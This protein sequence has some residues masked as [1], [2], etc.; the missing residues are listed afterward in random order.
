MNDCGQPVDNYYRPMPDG[1][2][3]PCTRE[4][5]EALVALSERD[6]DVDYN[7]FPIYDKT[8]K[9]QYRTANGFKLQGK[10]IAQTHLEQAGATT[11]ETP[12]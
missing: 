8:N 3:E 2:W 4:T 11:S 5:A 12:C 7:S 1:S 6:A 9:G 10:G